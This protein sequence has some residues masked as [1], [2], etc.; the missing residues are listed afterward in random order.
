MT[1][2]VAP[3]TVLIPPNDSYNIVNVNVPID[4]THTMFHFIAW[5]DDPASVPDVETWRKFLGAQPGI[6]LDDEYRMRRNVDN[7]FWQDREAM[8][9]GNFTGIRGIPNQD[10]AMWVTM[11]PIAD[12]E[13]DLLGASDLAIV[14]FRRQMVEAAQARS[15]MANRRSARV[16]RAF[17]PAFARTS[18][19][20]RRRPTGGRSASATM[21]SRPLTRGSPCAPMPKL[22]ALGGDRRLRPDA[23]ADRRH[24]SDR[25]RRS[26]ST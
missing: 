5:S 9:A 23:T 1:V 20:C 2:F 13:R 8:K 26:R 22:R 16:R 10:I 17:P 4:D 6:D 7:R 24:R 14:E 25:R 3:F 12:R 21:R 18:R 15:A 19:S 11:G